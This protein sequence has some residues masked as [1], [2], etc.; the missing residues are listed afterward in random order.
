[1]P[2]EVAGV[3]VVAQQAEGTYAIRPLA[4]FPRR[5]RGVQHV[6]GFLGAGFAIVSGLQ[7]ERQQSSP[8]KTGNRQP[9]KSPI[10]E[11]P[12]RPAYARGAQPK[13]FDAT[14]HENVYDNSAKIRLL[15]GRRDRAGSPEG[16]KSR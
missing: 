6:P 11:N 2:G 1:M 12:L 7:T 8:G 9:S 3:N 14:Y 10:H 13:T 5:S 15:P 4:G 16:S